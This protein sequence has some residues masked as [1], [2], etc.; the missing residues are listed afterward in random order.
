MCA[1]KQQTCGTYFNSCVE[2]PLAILNCVADLILSIC[3]MLRKQDKVLEMFE[4]KEYKDKTVTLLFHLYL[5]RNFSLF[6]FCWVLF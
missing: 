5:T 6:V 4:Y 3:K 2:R 1:F